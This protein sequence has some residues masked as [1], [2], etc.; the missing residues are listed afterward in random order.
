MSNNRQPFVR[1]LSEH[2]DTSSNC[3][4]LRADDYLKYQQAAEI[5][6]RAKAEAEETLQNAH[7]IYRQERERGYKEGRA[8]ACEES[9][10]QLLI[11]SDKA[12]TYLQQ[13]ESQ[14]VMVELQRWSG[15]SVVLS[16]RR[17]LSMW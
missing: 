6:S 3:K 11:M 14:L 12:V 2:V 4:L 1:V 15:L 17:L 5:V 7:S 9:A 8:Q 16:Y 13:L 10:E